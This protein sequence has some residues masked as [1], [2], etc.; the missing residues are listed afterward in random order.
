VVKDDSHLL[1]CLDLKRDCYDDVTPANC[2][3]E[4]GEKMAAR[5][6]TF[7]TVALG[8][9]SCVSLLTACGSSEKAGTVPPLPVRVVAAGR[10]DVPLYVELVGATLGTQD[11]PIRARVEGFLETLEFQ[12]GRFVKKGDVLYTIDARPFQAM[13]VS[14]QSTLAAARTNLAKAASDL[15]R[16]RPLAEMDAVSQQDLDGA[17]AMEAAARANVRASEAG[18]DLAEIELSYTRIIAPIDGLIGIS[19]ARPGEF[20]GREPNPVVLNTLSDINPIRVRFSIAER[21]YLVLARTYVDA[22][23]GNRK[24]SPPDSNLVLLLADNSEHPYTGTVTA[25]A[26]SIDPETGTFTV[27][28]SFPNPDNVV[29]P[30][31]FARVRVLYRELTDVVVV[32]RRAIVELQ[33]LFRVYVVESDNS[34]AIRNVTI[35]P[36]SGNMLVIESGLDGGESIIVDGIQ[37]VRPGMQVVPQPFA[38]PDTHSRQDEL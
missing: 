22:T 36:V 11:V 28:A 25:T 35:G 20:V 7:T 12:E 38:D 16:I 21:E 34:V 14:A 6:A 1:L 27:E 4:K 24:E 2:P 26:Q 18:V 31:Q 29:L 8:A 13:L 32:P 3:R 33:G 15:G 19:K 9:I 30:G 10:E 5:L 17:I 37:K 23:G